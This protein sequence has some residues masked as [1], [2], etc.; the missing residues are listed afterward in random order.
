[1]G[2]VN[3]AAARVRAPREPSSGKG[4]GATLTEQQGQHGVVAILHHYR[5]I[6]EERPAMA[7]TE[8]VPI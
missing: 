7:N 5:V 1:M 8:G 6:K 2:H 3:R 4:A